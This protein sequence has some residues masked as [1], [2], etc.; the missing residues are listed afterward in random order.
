MKYSMKREANKKPEFKP[1]SVTIILGTKEEYV[2]FHD[3]IMSNF[4]KTDSHK[5]HGDVYDMGRNTAD[6]ASGSI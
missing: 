4:T 1:F 5:F 3:N 2:D 6:K